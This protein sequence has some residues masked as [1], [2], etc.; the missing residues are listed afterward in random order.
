VDVFLEA[1]E[2]AERGDVL[3]V[4]NAGRTDEAC[5]GDLVT[6]EVGNAGL[7]RSFRDQAAFW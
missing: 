7:G 4:E 5:V 6:L 3:V 2:V 1:L